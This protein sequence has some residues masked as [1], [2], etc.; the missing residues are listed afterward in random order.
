MGLDTWLGGNSI[1][2]A[3]YVKQV[4]MGGQQQLTYQNLPNYLS[5]LYTITPGA[6]RGRLIGGNLSVFVAMIGSQY[7]LKEHTRNAILFLEGK[8]SNLYL[9]MFI[10]RSDHLID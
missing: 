6:A 8:K 7:L 9:I 2:N 10:S 4:V 3:N 5:G 1:Y